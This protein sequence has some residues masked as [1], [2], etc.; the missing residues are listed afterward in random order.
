MG[1]KMTHKDRHKM[2]DD[3]LPQPNLL[4]VFIVCLLAVGGLF[5]AYEIVERTLLKGVSPGVIHALHIL[6]GVSAAT[7]ASVLATL[8]LLRQTQDRASDVVLTPSK[9][10][11]KHR[12]QNVRL[13]TKIVIPMVVL[14]VLPSIGVGIFTISR[15]QKSLRQG[16]IQ[17]VDF[18]TAS[19]AQAIQEFLQEVQQDLLF[20][21]RIKGIREFAVAQAE[22][23]PNGLTSCAARSS[24]SF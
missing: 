5:F 16:A 7:I 21:S 10:S 18:D 11:W 14:A 23:A 3:Q 1:A 19:K 15:M 20:L 4:R 13:R 2:K 12:M 9:K 17:R 8:V 6:R 22:G 24:R